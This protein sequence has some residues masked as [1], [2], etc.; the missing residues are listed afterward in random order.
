ME[1]ETPTS[2]VGF[3]L[4]LDLGYFPLFYFLREGREEREWW[5]LGSSSTKLVSW[6]LAV[7]GFAW[8]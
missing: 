4:P 2:L 5:P 1:L 8:V 7:V 6:Q 3:F